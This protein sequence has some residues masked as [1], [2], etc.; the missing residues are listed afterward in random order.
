MLRKRTTGPGVAGS[1]GRSQRPVNRQ[2]FP[3]WQMTRPRLARA[4]IELAREHRR[5][6]HVPTIAQLRMMAGFEAVSYTHL[7]LPTT[8]Y[9]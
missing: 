1:T 5:L 8:P 3:E 2:G 4:V 7:T 9:V 6:A